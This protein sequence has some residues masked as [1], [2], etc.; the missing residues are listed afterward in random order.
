MLLR[1][2]FRI[3]WT[4]IDYE[5]NK[6][7]VSIAYLSCARLTIHSAKPIVSNCARGAPVQLQFPSLRGPIMKV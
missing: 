1:T 7:I 3:C 4:Y 2:L 5:Y 6:A